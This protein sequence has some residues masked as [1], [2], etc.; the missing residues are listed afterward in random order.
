MLAGP[1]Q[2]KAFFP[3][4]LDSYLCT[5]ATCARGDGKPALSGPSLLNPFGISGF[6]V[7]GVKETE[8][9]STEQ[10]DEGSIRCLRS[11]LPSR[12][13]WTAS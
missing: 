10:P 13:R 2:D 12:D 8:E 11:G 7:E 4:L 5:A 3:S 9:E 6:E 1:D